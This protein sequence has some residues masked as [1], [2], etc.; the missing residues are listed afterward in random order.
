MDTTED[1]LVIAQ[2]LG[3]ALHVVFRTELEAKVTTKEDYLC[4]ENGKA[5][6]SKREVSEG[7]LPTC[8]SPRRFTHFDEVPINVDVQLVTEEDGRISH[9]GGKTWPNPSGRCDTTSQGHRA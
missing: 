3:K 2:K 7:R 5:H 4:Q 6:R 8:H 1:W 9:G